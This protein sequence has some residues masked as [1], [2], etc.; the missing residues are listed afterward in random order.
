MICSWRRAM[1]RLKNHRDSHPQTNTSEFLTYLPLILKTVLGFFCLFFKVTKSYRVF[2]NYH[3]H[4]F[5]HRFILFF[6]KASWKWM[7]QFFLA[8]FFFQPVPTILLCSR[9]GT[10]VRDL[11]S[12][13]ASHIH[14]TK[15]EAILK[16]NVTNKPLIKIM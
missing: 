11:W 16:G 14:V 3:L 2:K 6:E 8:S 7:D 4:F 12:Y 1:G 13:L 10:G 9:Y 5:I 15:L